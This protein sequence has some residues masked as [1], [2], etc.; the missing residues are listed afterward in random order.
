MRKPPCTDTVNPAAPDG[1]LRA[2]PNQLASSRTWGGAIQ[3]RAAGAVDAIGGILV[4]GLERW[5]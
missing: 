3:V 1:Q 2:A 5:L 4:S